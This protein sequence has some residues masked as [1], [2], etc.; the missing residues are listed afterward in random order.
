[1]KTNDVTNTIR[2]VPAASVMCMKNST[3]SVALKV[4]ISSASGR[5]SD[6]EVHVPGP[7]PSARVQTSRMPQTTK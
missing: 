6:A 2:F 5:F 4:A 7:R 3:T 1:M